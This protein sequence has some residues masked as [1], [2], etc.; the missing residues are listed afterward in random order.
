M[1]DVQIVEVTLSDGSKAYSV[2]FGNV[3]LDAVSFG[4]A[5]ILAAKIL[6]AIEEH[7]N[8]DVRIIYG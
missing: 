4:D 6:D 3:Y 8:E 7:T 2:F 5:E 1:V